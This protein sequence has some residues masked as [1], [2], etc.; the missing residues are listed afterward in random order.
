MAFTVGRPNVSGMFQSRA[1]EELAKQK[2]ALE[3]NAFQWQVEDR[4]DQKI[5]GKVAK[6][7]VE[8]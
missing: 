6:N 7:I 4:N 2:F 1:N 8:A 5:Q 3:K